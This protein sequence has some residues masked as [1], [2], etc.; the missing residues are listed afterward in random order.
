MERR[1][2]RRITTTPVAL[3]L[4][5][6][7]I[8]FWES[9][10]PLFPI[11]IFCTAERSQTLSLGFGLVHLM[12]AA[13]FVLGL[14]SLRWPRARLTYVALILLCLCAL[15]VQAVLVAKHQLWCDFP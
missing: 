4:V 7:F 13:L 5:V 8:L 10:G 11:S 14:V 2:R 15:P 1:I 6:Q 9:L 3:L 12:L